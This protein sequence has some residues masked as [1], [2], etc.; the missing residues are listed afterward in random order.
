MVP[1]LLMGQQGSPGLGT[2]EGRQDL[3]RRYGDAL[4]RWAWARTGGD[5][6]EDVVQETFLA[7]FE[8]PDAYDPSR[9]EPWGWLVGLA[10]NRLKASR[11]GKRG[12]ELVEE[13][14]AEVPHPME[15]E[16]EGRRIRMALTSLPPEMQRLLKAHCLDGRPASST[17]WDR[18]QAAKA[19]FRKA[20]REMGVDA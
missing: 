12:L 17:A 15:A 3:V 16:E 7:A 11:K 18:L 10:L 9:G 4:Y 2:P 1:V 6:A 8:R 19:A 14:A 20:A 13:P 5:G